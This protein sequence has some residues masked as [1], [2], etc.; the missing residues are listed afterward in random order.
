[1]D[2]YIDKDMYIE[3]YEPAWLDIIEFHTED[4]ITTASGDPHDFP[5]EENELPFVPK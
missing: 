1:M 3:K 4:V 2:M 5:Y